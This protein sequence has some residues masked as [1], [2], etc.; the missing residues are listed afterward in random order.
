[1]QLEKLQFADY[2]LDFDAYE[3][4]RRG[5]AVKL[6]R[7][8]MELLRLLVDRHDRLVTREDIAG[9]LWGPAV[10][11]DVDSSI[12]TAVLKLRRIFKDDPQRPTFIRQTFARIEPLRVW[13]STTTGSPFVP[14]A[15]CMG[16][17]LMS[18]AR[19]S[20]RCQPFWSSRCRK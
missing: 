7:I 8:P 12:N 9:K 20:S 17:W 4:T 13:I 3:L 18:V 15:G 19:Y 2:E 1:M 10:F 16:S 14:I 11:L 5:R 6:E